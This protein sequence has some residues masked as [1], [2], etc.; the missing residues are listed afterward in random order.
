MGLLMCLVG[1]IDFNLVFLR[2]CC[3]RSESYW[4]SYSKS[5][6]GLSLWVGGL[7]LLEVSKKFICIKVWVFIFGDE[8]VKNNEYNLVRIF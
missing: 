7:F 5:F 3:K 4:E 2:G 8:R 6:L 1:L